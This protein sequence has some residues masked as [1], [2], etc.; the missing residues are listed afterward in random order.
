MKKKK[1]KFKITEQQMSGYLGDSKFNQ[2]I[3]WLLT[4]P[5]EEL[6]DS[7]FSAYKEMQKNGQNEIWLIDYFESKLSEEIVEFV[8]WN[9]NVLKV[10]TSL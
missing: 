8:D 2:A 6:S 4:I 3:L 10:K 5:K 1:E 7:M 9:D